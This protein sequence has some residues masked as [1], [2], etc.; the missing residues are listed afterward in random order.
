MVKQDENLGS[1]PTGFLVRTEFGSGVFTH[2]P[3]SGEVYR[4]F[5]K[6]KRR[7]SNGTMLPSRTG[8]SALFLS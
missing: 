5:L 4:T 6:N 7:S 2:T 3:S 8:K 1:F